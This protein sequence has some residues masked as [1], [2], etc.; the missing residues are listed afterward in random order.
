MK[1]DSPVVLRCLLLSA[2]TVQRHIEE[3]D[4][5]FEKTMTSELQHYMFTVQLV[6]SKLLDVQIF[7]WL[8]SGFIVHP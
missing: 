8:M 5:D 4:N 7:S 1:K 3:M 2:N 6:E